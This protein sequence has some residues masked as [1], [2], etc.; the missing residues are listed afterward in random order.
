MIKITQILLTLLVITLLTS[1]DFI[2]NSFTYKDKTEELVEA[3]IDEDYDK[4]YNQ[5]AT[6]HEIATDV[7]K[8]TLKD[9]LIEF[10]ELVVKNF[11][12]ELEYTFIKSEKKFS[13]KEEGNTPPNTTIALVEFK[14]DKDFGV[15]QLLFDDESGKIL[16]I[17]PLDIKEPIPSMTIFWLFGILTISIPIFNI[18][19]I[20]QIKRSN[21]SKKWLKYLA[22]IILNIPSI[23]YTAISGLSFQLIKFQILLGFGFNYNSFY[24]SYWEFG[25]PLG[26]IYWFWKLRNNKAET[27][28]KKPITK[29][30]TF[31]QGES[32]IIEKN[33]NE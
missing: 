5:F 25:I 2:R 8:E 7:D 20:R 23:S 24:D 6:E 33:D 21:L 31:E 10:R 29:T 19:V 4:A 13:T 32:T 12:T 18:Y 16:N 22:V 15:F 1:C 27:I 11:G 28:K 3:I 14:N 26:G 17:D 30:D 9:G